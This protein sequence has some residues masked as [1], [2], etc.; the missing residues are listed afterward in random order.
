MDD[1]TRKNLEGLSAAL[2]KTVNSRHAISPSDLSLHCAAARAELGV[3]HPALGEKKDSTRWAW[4][5]GRGAA[6]LFVSLHPVLLTLKRATN[7]ILASTFKAATRTISLAV[8]DRFS[9]IAALEH[10]T[11]TWTEST[12]HKQVIP[13]QPGRPRPYCSQ[14]RTRG[15]SPSPYAVSGR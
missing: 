14:P 8:P 9:R 13:P 2:A 3:F 4:F 15:G 6:D 10:L 12:S 1:L 7:F 11:T 5:I